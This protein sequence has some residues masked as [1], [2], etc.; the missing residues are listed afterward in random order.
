MRRHFGQR[1]DSFR[2]IDEV[3]RL[4]RALASYM[5][6]I[7]RAGYCADH[8]ASDQAM[9]NST[10]PDGVKV[11][12]EVLK[13]VDTKALEDELKART[14]NA[15]RKKPQLDEPVHPADDAQQH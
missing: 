7:S 5:R 2:L 12:S 1:R 14:V 4:Y 13:E 10:Q 11:V 3:T 6:L 9:T 15:G 8:H